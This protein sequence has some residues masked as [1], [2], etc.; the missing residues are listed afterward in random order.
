MD[1]LK[2]PLTPESGASGAVRL[3]QLMERTG[4]SMRIPRLCMV[5]AG[6][7]NRML[8]SENGKAG[9]VRRLLEPLMHTVLVPDDPAI[10]TVDRQGGR[11]Y[12]G[13]WLA[14]LRPGGRLQ[15]FEESPERSTYRVGP[16]QV[17]FLVKADAVRLEVALAS[18]VAKYT[19][20]L[21]MI[22]FNQYWSRQVPDLKPTAG[23]PQD[24]RRF[25]GD[26]ESAGVLPEDVDL[27]IRRL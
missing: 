24:A 8:I 26:L 2:L 27:L 23:Y 18:M 16:H 5:P 25:I 20:E 9:A 22:L 7:F 14:E 13:E 21:A 17:T 19:R 3:Q 12:Y 6:E 10:F 1:E 15:A 4:V 11:R